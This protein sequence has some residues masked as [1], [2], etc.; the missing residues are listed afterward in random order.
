MS[1]VMIVT[2]GARGIGRAIV[3]RAAQAG[4]AVCVN[5]SRARDKAQALVAEIESDGGRASAAQADVADEAQVVAMF[6]EVDARLG[7]VTAL[8]NNVRPEP[9]LS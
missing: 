9:S 8:V 1:G 6:E 2:G 5:Y 7:P 4:Y 3:K